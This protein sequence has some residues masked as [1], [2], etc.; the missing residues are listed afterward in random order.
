MTADAVKALALDRNNN[1]W[2]GNSMG[3]HQLINNE[4]LSFDERAG[5]TSKSIDYRCLHFDSNNRIWAGT[6]S[7][8]VVSSPLAL[9]HKTVTPIILSLLIDNEREIAFNPVGTTLNNKSFVTMKVGVPEYP[10][11][12]LRVEMRLQ[13][14]DTAWIPVGKSEE[15]I[16]ANLDAGQYTLL[17]RARQYG[18]FLYSKPLYWSFT[19][20]RSWYFRWWA[21]LI[22][23]AML[24]VIFWFSMKWYTTKLKRNN[25]HLEKAINERTREISAQK[26]QIEA[27]NQSIVYTN[28]AL[29]KTN[30]EL[31]AAKAKAEEAS[32][33]KSKFLSVMTHELRTPMNAVIGF[34]HLLIQNNPRTDQ[35]EDLK[36][37][38]FSAENL[39]A[40]IN[41]ILDFNKIEAEKINLEQIEFNLKNLIEEIMASMKI[42]ARQKNVKVQLHY[43][44]DLPLYIL[45]DPL[46][47]S[48]IMNNLLSNALK[49]IEKGSVTIDLKLNS[50]TQTDVV[51]DFSITD[52]GIGIDNASLETIFDTFTQASSE[53]S[54]KYGGT[55]LG[56][57]ITQKLLELFG[58]KIQV[59][60]EFGKG[61][62]FYFSI[63]FTEGSDVATGT[64]TGETAYDFSLFDNQRVLLV[65]DNKVNKL[66][67]T[68]FLSG[69]NLNVEI[70]DNG[71]IAV[72]KIKHQPFDLILMDLQMPEMDGYQAAAAIRN[73]GVEPFISIPII[74]LTASS[75][76]DVYENIFLSGMDDFISKP[77]NPIE[78]HAKIVKHL[79]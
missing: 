41:N 69:W 17:I 6:V 38:R 61:T 73:Y 26:E 25:E 46:R 70:A 35:L 74:A 33:A 63:R 10:A 48:Q 32:D 18:N 60:S 39:L 59:E 34:S 71:L 53:T 62:R 21:I 23:A 3:L 65:E 19:V 58:S 9:P 76:A 14:R 72:E 51:I 42:R 45:G 50:R 2:F 29:E 30:A 47:L 56:L 77:F 16:L 7:G 43:D 11:K 4:I 27:Q 31:Q 55:G 8:L 64:E 66:I 28:E 15:I 13:G 78:L 20:T 12:Y 75:K 57:S 5:M 49:F 40:L 44:P 36:T 52:T 1:V 22:A 37:L 54:R 79:L 68:K 67:A 24:L